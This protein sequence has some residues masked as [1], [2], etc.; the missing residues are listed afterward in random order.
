MKRFFLTL[1]VAVATTITANAENYDFLTI[2]K[3]D[4]TAVSFNSTDLTI[5][6][7]DGN[8]IASQGG[9]Q[10]TFELIKLSKMFF[11]S[12]TD[13]QIF[14]TDAVETGDVFDLQG[15]RIASKIRLKDL[16]NQLP[17]GVY[18]VKNGQK[19]VKMT[20]K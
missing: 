3:M 1:A 9:Q 7:A 10:T 6:F 17:K 14:S 19:N 18:I 4:G 15:R 8:L 11:S 2:Q 12:T 20:V 16:Q 13:V 5:T